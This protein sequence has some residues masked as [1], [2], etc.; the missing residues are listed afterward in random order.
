MLKIDIYMYDIPC[1]AEIIDFSKIIIGSCKFMQLTSFSC[2]V[3][4]HI[5][6]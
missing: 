5:I 1:M 3:N 4:P 2:V 6:V